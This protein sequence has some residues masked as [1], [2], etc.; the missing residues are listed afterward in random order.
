M[1]TMARVTGLTVALTAAG[2]AGAAAQQRGVTANEVVMGM[3]TD[4]S[5]VAATYGVSSSNG[6]KMR[7][8]ELNAV[9]GVEGRK[10][11][12]VVEDQAYQV[13]KA[14]QAC[15][16][17][18]NRDKIF[19]MV[20]PLGTPMNQ[21]CFKDQ[22][23]AGV[24]QA[25][26]AR[27]IAHEQFDLELFLE[28]AQHTFEAIGLDVNTE[29]IDAARAIGVDA[30][31]GGFLETEVP[32]P[33]DVVCLWDTIEHLLDPRAYLERARDVLVSHQRRRTLEAPSTL[34]RNVQQ[35][36]LTRG[37]CLGSLSAEQ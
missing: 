10:I 31:F 6:V 16:K 27:A 20:A 24:R 2:I 15:N 5:G 18:I 21:A 35:A 3:H 11:R 19:A 34:V 28:Q 9:G 4:L 22:F 26:Q 13:P 23:A 32:A 25:H 1:R 30:R 37:R 36:P 8:D 33:F 14:V 12:L 7:F 17:L 29:A